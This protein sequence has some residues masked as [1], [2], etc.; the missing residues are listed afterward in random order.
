MLHHL[1][2]RNYRSLR[3]EAVEL[4]NPTLHPAAMGV[5]LDVLRSATKSSQVVVT[6]HSPDLLD[7]K[8][9]KDRH[10]R[11]VSWEDGATRI[12]RVAPSVGRAMSEQLFGA[13]DL[14]RSN[15]LNGAKHT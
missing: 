5:M 14:L 9:I 12:E 10:L 1:N 3:S 4:D 6:T 8:W 11:L 13:G 15:A 7:A 2:I